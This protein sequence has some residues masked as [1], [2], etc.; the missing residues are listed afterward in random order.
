MHSPP[1]N[2][3]VR[4]VRVVREPLLQLWDL[5]HR[6]DEGP[7]ALLPLGVEEAPCPSTSSGGGDGSS[8]ESEKGGR[9]EERSRITQLLVCNI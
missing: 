3:C 1:G 8:A 5:R 7:V 2:Q 4:R 9:R 6:V